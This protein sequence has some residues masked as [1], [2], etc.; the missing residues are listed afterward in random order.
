MKPIPPGRSTSY[1]VVPTSQHL[2]AAIGNPGVAAVATTALIL[3]IEEACYLAV[4]PFY[5]EGEATVGTKVE[6]EH[7]AA[8]FAGAPLLC[9]AEVIGVEGRRIDFAAEITSGDKIVM[10][11]RH[12]R[13]IV[14]LKRFLGS[15]RSSLEGAASVVASVT[16]RLDFWFDFTSPWCYLATARIGGIAHRHGAKLAWRPVHLA[17]LIETVGGRRPLE[18]AAPFVEWYRQDILDHAAL[19]GL[20]F[21]QHPRYPL[22]PARALRA[23]IWAEEQGKGEAFA[24]PLLKGYWSEETDIEE[25]E[26]LRAAAAGAGLDPNAVEQVVGDGP[27][28][29]KLEAN[30]AEAVAQGLFGLPTTIHEG[31]LYWGNDRLDLLERHLE[32]RRAAR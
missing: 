29:H 31:K 20:P 18:G 15:P 7:R 24:L 11:G 12:Q 9:K 21:K 22:R 3:F 4:A 32:R 6:V 27:Y 14:D 1:S 8:C 26:V 10:T 17:K 19:L 16:P 30:L 2:A 23:A 25:L 5:E 13:A 28:K